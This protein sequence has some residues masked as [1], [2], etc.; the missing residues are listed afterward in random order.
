[1]HMQHG[2]ALWRGR[3]GA[4]PPAFVGMPDRGIGGNDVTV[5]VGAALP[6]RAPNLYTAS[7][8]PITTP[9]TAWRIATTACPSAAVAP[10]F[11]ACTFDPHLVYGER[12]RPWLA[13]YGRSAVYLSY[14]T[15]SQNVLSGHMSV[16]RSDDGGRT[17]SLVG[18][19][20][21]PL[22]TATAPLHGWP[23]PLAVDARNGSVYEAF[24]TDTPEAPSDQVF[25]RI[26]V[27]ASRDGGLTW[28]DVTAY[29]GPAGTDTGNMWPGLA[30]DAAGRLYVAWST[31]RHVVLSSSGDGGATWSAPTQV[32][33]PLDGIRTGVLPWVA[34]GATGHVALAWYGTAASSNLAATARWRVMFAESHDG[35]R[36]FSE[37]AATGIVHQ[38][39]VCTKGDVCPWPQRQLLD[40]FGLVLDPRT[41]HAAIAYSRSIEF[42]DYRACR[43]AANCPQTYYV[44]ELPG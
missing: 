39:P 14:L 42:G 31:R 28:R 2:T 23:S 41:D 7:L 13:A 10:G 44:E 32:D 8:V 15:R 17:W 27:A 11:A 1:M 12:D 25:N 34:A 38:G 30:V 43:R 26:V 3:F 36:S 6:G 20:V 22:T 9:I 24:A 16:Q 18:D 5:A 35:G 40:D 4:T 33:A 21:A 37:A 29:R 19:P